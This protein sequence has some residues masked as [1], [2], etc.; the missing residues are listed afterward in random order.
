[1]TRLQ[2]FSWLTLLLT[3]NLAKI[4]AQSTDTTALVIQDK[5]AY[6]ATIASSPIK[7]MVNVNKLI[8][9]LKM[10]LRYASKNNFTGKR[11][12]PPSSTTCYLREEAASA[13][14][15]VSDSLS[16]RGFDL[17]IFDAYRPYAVTARFWKLIRDERYVANPRLGSGHNRGIAIDLT[18]VDKST[19]VEIDMGTGFDNF[20]TAAHHSYL[21]LQPQVLINRKILKEIMEH[22]GFKSLET[23]W[24]HYSLPNPKRYEVLNLSFRELAD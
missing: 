10:E 22:F 6:L 7:R 2:Q 5:K 16:K 19:G 20:S 15:A 23:E 17:K 9:S 21:E 4:V 11:M 13:L 14:K 8:P 12:Y 24:W 1:M 18:L 3:L